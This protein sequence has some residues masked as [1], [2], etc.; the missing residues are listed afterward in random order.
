[1]TDAVLSALGTYPQMEFLAVGDI[2]LD[3]RFS[4]C[5]ERVRTLPLQPWDELPDVI[6]QIDVNLAPLEDNP[7]TECKSCVKYLE[8]ALLGVPTV[9][10]P[11]PDYVR[12][13]EHGRNGLLAETP[14]EWLDSLGRLVSDSDARRALGVNA[15]QDVRREHTTAA[16][17]ERLA[18]ALNS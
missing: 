17:A 12:V 15:R 1:V 14:S 6:S 16:Q 10:S 5:H 11:R 7:F 18:D 8:A 13:I 3:E 9:A 4:A 2:S